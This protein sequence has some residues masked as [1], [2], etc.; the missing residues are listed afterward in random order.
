[1]DLQK[2]WMTMSQAKML[3]NIGGAGVGKQKVAG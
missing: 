1:M 3:K 2:N